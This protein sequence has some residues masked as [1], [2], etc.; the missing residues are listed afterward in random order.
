MMLQATDKVFTGSI[1]KIYDTY[2]VPLIF[3]AYADDLA[4]RTA[5]LPARQVLEIAAGSGVVTRALAATLPSD[6]AIVSTDLNPAMIEH[7]KSVGTRRAVEWR[8]A[9]AMQLPFDDARFDVV[10]C[11]FCAM[12]FP[13]KGRAFA[14]ARRV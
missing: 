10:V 6:V 13:D 11:Q 12:F 14:E 4:R 8:V 2:L 5:S 3:Q 7:A 9:D 1:P